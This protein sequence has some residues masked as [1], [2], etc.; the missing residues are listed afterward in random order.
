MYDVTLMNK[1]IRFILTR[2]HKVNYH[3]HQV[4]QCKPK[5][6]LGGCMHKGSLV[7][8]RCD[9]LSDEKDEQLV[10]LNLPL[11]SKAIIKV[12][13]ISITCRYVFV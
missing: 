6:T 2:M 5:S 1:G 10:D 8:K 7:I 13:Y 11:H 9:V 12:R 4:T 3:L